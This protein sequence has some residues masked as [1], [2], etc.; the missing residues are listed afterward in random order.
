MAMVKFETASGESTSKPLLPFRHSAD[1]T[2]S[3]EIFHAAAL[4]RHL[5]V[6]V[7]QTWGSTA[8]LKTS[9]TV[10]DVSSRGLHLQ[11]PYDGFDG[12]AIHQFLQPS[13]HDVVFDAC[14]T[15]T[16]LT[17]QFRELS[18]GQDSDARSL[19]LS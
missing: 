19:A 7:S 9:H 15:S 12:G 2:C 17:L 1:L 8:M 6:Q 11:Q 5:T 14:H 10:D 3:A 18:T 13:A 16:S 4:D